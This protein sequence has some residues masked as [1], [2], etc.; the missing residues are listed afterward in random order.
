MLLVVLPQ[1]ER[2]QPVV[3]PA[4]RR[5]PTCVQSTRIWDRSARGPSS[6]YQPA[7]AETLYQGCVHACAPLQTPDTHRPVDGS[8]A[9]L[10]WSS[11]RHWHGCACCKYLRAGRKAHRAMVQGRLR[12]TRAVC[13]QNGLLTIAAH[14]MPLPADRPG[15]LCRTAISIFAVHLRCLWGKGGMQAHKLGGTRPASPSKLSETASHSRT[16]LGQ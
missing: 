1:P 3:H 16:A 6:K 7:Y 10:P 2:Q 13:R 8:A 12:L 15:P 11:W 4:C 9:G 14:E 5:Q